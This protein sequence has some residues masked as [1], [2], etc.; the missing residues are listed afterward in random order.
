MR[1]TLKHSCFTFDKTQ[2]EQFQG[3]LD[4]KEGNKNKEG[5]K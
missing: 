5:K 1:Y 3:L 4:N 2:V